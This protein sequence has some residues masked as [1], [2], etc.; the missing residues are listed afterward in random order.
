MNDKITYASAFVLLVLLMLTAGSLAAEK[1][2]LQKWDFGYVPQKSVVG[3]VFYLKNSG[4]KAL[5]VTNIKPGCSC[6]SVSELDGPIAPGDSAAITVTFKSGRYHYRVQKTTLIVTDDPETPKHRLSILAYVYADKDTT[7]F[8]SVTP[9]KLTWEA[10]TGQQVF[11][12]ET[13]EFINRRPDTIQIELLDI[14]DTLIN[15]SLSDATLAPGAGASLVLTPR[16]NVAACKITDVSVTIK[17]EKGRHTI[18]TIP[19]KFKY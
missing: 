15:W 2:P 7:G 3:H 16:K 9:P 10:K 13:I 6:T 1:A 4:E 19:L 17:F 18:I 12:P 5:T 14:P 8:I 11:G